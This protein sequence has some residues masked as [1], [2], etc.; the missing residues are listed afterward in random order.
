MVPLYDG[1]PIDHGTVLHTVLE[2]K[3]D[4]IKNGLTWFG[5]VMRM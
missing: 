2:L 5:R 3:V 4:E 1:N